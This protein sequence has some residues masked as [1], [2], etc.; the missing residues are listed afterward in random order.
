MHG[1]AEQSAARPPVEVDEKLFVEEWVGR[2]SGFRDECGGWRSSF[3]VLLL[4][5]AD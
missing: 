5:L 1:C 4:S 3:L 2:G